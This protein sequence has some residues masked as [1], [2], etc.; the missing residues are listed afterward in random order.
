MFDDVKT[1]RIQLYKIALKYSLSP[2]LID[3]RALSPL[4][5]SPVNTELVGDSLIVL[6]DQHQSDVLFPPLPREL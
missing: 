5:Y 3:V 1:S 6:P 4:S 2:T